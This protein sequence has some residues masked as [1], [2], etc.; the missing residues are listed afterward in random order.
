MRLTFNVKTL[1]LAIAFAGTPVAAA[2]FS[3]IIAFGDSLTDAGQFPDSDALNNGVYQNHRF[4]NRGSNG[5]REKVAIQ[6]LSES[7]GA[8]PLYASAPFL[9]SLATGDPIGTDYAVGGYKTDEILASITD[10]DG[11]VLR[12]PGH[13]TQIS[14]GYL[15][16]NPKADK[17]ALYYINGGGNNLI[18]A[19]SQVLASPGTSVSDHY[20]AASADELIQGANALS[21]AGAQYIMVS[22][23]PDLGK[24]P[25]AA[26]LDNIRS[27]IADQLTNA[28]N[29]FNNTLYQSINA[30]SANIITVDQLGLMQEILASPEK[31]GFANDISGALSTTCYDD[32]DKA[33]PECLENTVYGISNPTTGDP[34]KLL[35]NDAVHPTAASQQIISDYMLSIL[36]AG[37][38]IGLLPQMGHGITSNTLDTISQQLAFNRSSEQNP[39][40]LFATGAALDNDYASG[41]NTSSTDG[42]EDAALLGVSYRLSDQWLLGAAINTQYTDLDTYYNSH[43]EVDSIGFSGFFRYQQ[44]DHRIGVEANYN[45]LDYGKI[46]RSVMLGQNIR[47]HEGDTG[48]RSYGIGTHYAYTLHREGKLS[49]GPTLSLQYQYTHVDGYSEDGE[50]MSTSLSFDDQD[51]TSWVA[52][53]GVYI[54]WAS[55]DNKLT[56]STELKVRREINDDDSHVDVALQSINTKSFELSGYEQTSRVWSEGSIAASYLITESMSANTGFRYSDGEQEVRMVHVG[57]GAAF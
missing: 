25:F 31:F 11:F 39:W 50:I 21:K 6:R 40:Y 52:D 12:V 44:G 33:T 24:S 19:A 45:N 1:V 14:D 36:N 15:M 54:N 27:G 43:F 5:V 49:Y 13:D 3:Q 55:S 2:P 32:E 48:G 22:N 46:E 57:I 37:S 53:A 20:S 8:G 38:E 16:T 56:L 30:S 23:L 34:S 10:K 9:P 17:N 26:L 35:F 47:Y 18:N 41:G 28:V 42:D 4:T 29:D 51:Y 7:L